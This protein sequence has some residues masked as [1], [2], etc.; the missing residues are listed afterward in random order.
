MAKDEGGGKGFQYHLSS[1]LVGTVMWGV[2]L[3]VYCVF[4]AFKIDDPILGQAFLLLTGL[5]VGNLTIAQGK[6]QTKVEQ[7]LETKIEKLT[8]VAK[9]EHPDITDEELP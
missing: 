7:Q 1:G 6:K 3:V 5:W 8:E 9:K 2:V 4:K